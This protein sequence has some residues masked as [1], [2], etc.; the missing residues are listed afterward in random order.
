MALP[1][2]AARLGRPTGKERDKATLTLPLIHHPEAAG[3]DGRGE[4]LDLLE[5]ACSG[6]RGAAEQL[7]RAMDRTGSIEYA[8]G[9]AARR[10]EYARTLI[11]PL[12]D[13]PAK[14][15]LL[16]AADTLVKRDR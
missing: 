8:R 12:V 16:L 6:D 9:E 10:I 14:R 1:P 13:S 4:S 7:L 3:A 11:E 2:T 5:R 15:H